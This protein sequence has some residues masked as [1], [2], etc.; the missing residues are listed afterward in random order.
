MN[1]LLARLHGI[2]FPSAILSKICRIAIQIYQIL[3]SVS[4]YTG[5]EQK[6]FDAWDK[7]KS[8]TYAS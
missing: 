1:Y 3:E 2:A 8:I 4:I 5:R 7:F 6:Q